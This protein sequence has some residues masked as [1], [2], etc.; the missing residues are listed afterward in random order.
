MG[1]NFDEETHIARIWEMSLGD[2]LPNSIYRKTDFFP[3][4]FFDSSF[5]RNINLPVIEPE[6]LE[7]TGKLEN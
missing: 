7:R 1:A 6:C 5:S 4:V 2:I 3:P